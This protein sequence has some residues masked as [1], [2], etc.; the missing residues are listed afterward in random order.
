MEKNTMI[1]N[2]PR[3]AL[4]TMSAWEICIQDKRKR[5]KQIWEIEKYLLCQVY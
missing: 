1:Q 5:E 4:T 2:Q 3:D